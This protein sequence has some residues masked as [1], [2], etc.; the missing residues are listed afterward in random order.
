MLEEFGYCKRVM[1]KHFNKNLI[2]TEKAEQ[3]FGSSNTCLIYEKLIDDEKT[4]DHW[5][6]RRIKTSYK[7]LVKILSDNHFKYLSEEFN[8]QDWVTIFRIIS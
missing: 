4:R 5:Y 1:K 2:L 7:K 8:L 3:T 6:N